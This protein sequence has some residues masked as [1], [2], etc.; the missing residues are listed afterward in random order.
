MVQPISFVGLI[1]DRGRELAAEV[2]EDLVNE[3]GVVRKLITTRNPQANSM[4][5]QAHQVVH[6]MI[7]THN[8]K[9]KTDLNAIGSWQG[10]LAALG[11]VMRATVAAY[12][13]ACH[14]GTTGLW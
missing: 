9:N 3:W 6:S 7:A 13:H 14:A 5:E 1:M 12:H 8:L 2:H 10:I 11:F 4:V